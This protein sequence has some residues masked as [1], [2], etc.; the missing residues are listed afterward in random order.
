MRQPFRLAVL[1]CDEPIP[2]VKEVYGSYGDM[3]ERQ[4][5]VNI[6]N[7]GLDSSNLL[8]SKWDVVDK[9][10]YPRLDDIDAVLLTGSRMWKLDIG[11]RMF[12]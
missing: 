1:E 7:Q 9:Q 5:Q 12:D 11:W 10:S 8:V 4:L 2:E 3:F 6:I